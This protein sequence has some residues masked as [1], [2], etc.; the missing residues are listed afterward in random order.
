[1]SYTL[2][3]IHLPI[4][5]LFI[6][7]TLQQAGYQAFIVGGAVRDIVLTQDEAG[8][9]EI[10]SDFDFTTNATP[11]ELLILFADSFCENDFGTVSIARKHLLEHISIHTASSI[12][13]ENDNNDTQLPNTDSTKVIDILQAT[14]LH[15]SLQSQPA[16]SL[17]QEINPL[18]KELYEITP[19]RS[20]EKYGTDYRKPSHFEW[21]ETLSEDLTRR[22]FTMNALAIAVDPG[23]LAEYFSTA[24]T[25]ISPTLQLISIPR[26]SYT[27]IDEHEGL[28]HIS[29]KVIHTVGDSNQ[30]FNEDALRMLRAIRFAVQL[31]MAIS[32][33][34]FLAIK[35]QSGLIKHISWERIRDEFLKVITSPFPKDG[36]EL[37]DQTGL[38][39]H[40]LP[41]LL[42]AKDVEQGGHHTTDVWTHSLDAL[43][44]CASVD[45][46]IRLATLLHDIGKPETCAL[47]NNTITFYNH[48][49]IGAHM[50]KDIARR[51]NLSKKDIDRVFLLVRHHMFYYQPDNTDAAIRRFM[52]K[53]GLENI[54]DMLILREADRLG[55]GARR[56]SWRL[57]EMKQRM[58]AQLHQPFSISDLA[59][60]GSDIMTTF[61]IPPGKIIGTVLQD[62]F[63]KVMDNP[64]LN[65]QEKLLSLAKDLI[66]RSES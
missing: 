1:M 37:L 56:T 29:G 48:E 36:I 57:E 62:L 3:T 58:I 32:D 53:V 41:E 21:G 47:Q 65:T 10:K 13:V 12:D 52:R 40:I 26:T 24:P 46:V 66:V 27:I 60:D 11:D 44:E 30:R 42:T 34:S 35:Q 31:N 23:F 22:D 9:S 19:Y 5:P 15:P 64:E 39:H 50:A 2:D 28:E 7:Y 45:P 43:E 63:E 38:L 25:Y 54:D 61:H 20:A 33:D 51:L 14:K 17:S 16:V 4:E 18:K 49:I 6:L 55:S 59:I 8:F